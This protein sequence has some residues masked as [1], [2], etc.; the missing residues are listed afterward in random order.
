[1]GDSFS[2]WADYQTGNERTVARLIIEC[3]AVVKV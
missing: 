1:M 3:E 2:G